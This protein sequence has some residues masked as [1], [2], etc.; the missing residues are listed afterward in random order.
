[1]S[2]PLRLSGFIYALYIKDTFIEYFESHEDAIRFAKHFYPNLE[3]IIKPVS[4]FR[5]EAKR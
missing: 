3:I 5:Y 1:M 4:Y 2:S